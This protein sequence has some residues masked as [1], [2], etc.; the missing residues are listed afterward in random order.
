MDIKELIYKIRGK[1]VMLDSDLA[2]L[3]QCKNGTK[4]INKA[5]K[6]NIN[7]FPEDF[8]FQLRKDEIDIMCSR[9]QIGTLNKR[10]ENIKYLPHVFTEQGV[11]MLASVLKSEIA[12][13]V[14]V[15]IMRAFVEMRHFI[16]DNLIEQKYI[17]KIV[18]ENHNRIISLEEIFECFKEKNNHLFIKGEYY[19]A[20]SIFID[21]LSSAKKEIIIIDNY[22]GKELLDIVKNVNQS[23]IIISSN[24]DETLKK[25]YKKEYNNVQFASSDSFHDRFIIVDKKLLYHCGTSFK[26]LGHK[27][28]SIN[29][30]EDKEYLKKIIDEIKPCL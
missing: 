14:S 20:Y 30:I 1:Q 24:I 8:C 5:V 29:K 26:D 23:I 12:S 25:K 2:K 4:D 10:G 22:A 11:A 18:I 7:R 17:N 21:I 9:F 13:K 6:R 28:T 15:S 27:I 3:Y 19:D 16:D